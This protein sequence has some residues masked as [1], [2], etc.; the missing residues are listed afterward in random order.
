M[1]G[2]RERDQRL[3]R[4]LLLPDITIKAL[5]VSHGFEARVCHHHGLG[6][7]AEFVSR[8]GLEVLHHHFG[9]LRDVVRVQ[10][11]KASQR[12]RRLFPLHVRIVFAGLEEFEVG[13]VGRVVLKH[14]EDESFLDC[15]PHRVF[16]EL[17][18]VA[19]EH[20]KCPVFGCC[21]ERKETQVR[22]PAAPGH[23]AE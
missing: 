22:L 14:V 20:G 12:A 16:V 7:A 1:Y 15:L 18:A 17:L 23:A 10:L 2:T 3:D 6:P 21:R 9:F 4:I 13:R 8:D 11:H 19:A 5:L